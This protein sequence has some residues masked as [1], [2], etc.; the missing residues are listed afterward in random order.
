MP[1]IHTLSAIGT[2]FM[3]TILEFPPRQRAYR[4]LAQ[5]ARAH[6]ARSKRDEEVAAFMALARQWEQLAHE[7]RGAG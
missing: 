1:E 2:E 5:E 3:A 7:A 4:E 6:A